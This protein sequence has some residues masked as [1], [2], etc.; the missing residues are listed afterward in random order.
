MSAP[1]HPVA[2]EAPSV[3][4]LRTELTRI[5]GSDPGQEHTGDP[6]LIEDLGLDSLGMAEAIVM[7]EAWFGIEPGRSGLMARDWRGMTVSSLFEDLCRIADS[8]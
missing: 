8:R 5:S 2:N 7:V 6:R 4:G 1:N 3:A